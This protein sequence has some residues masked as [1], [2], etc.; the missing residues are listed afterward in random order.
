FEEDP[1]VAVSLRGEDDERGA[2]PRRKGREVADEL[3]ERLIEHRLEGGIGE[4][5][6]V[7]EAGNGLFDPR[8]N[9]LHARVDDP[10]LENVSD[11]GVD[12]RATETVSEDHQAAASGIVPIEVLLKFV[13]IRQKLDQLALADRLRGALARVEGQLF[14]WRYGRREPPPSDEDPDRSERPE[15]SFRFF[16]HH[17]HVRR[18]PG[19]QS[20]DAADVA[21]AKPRVARPAV[22]EEKQKYPRR[23]GPRRFVPEG[24]EQQ[25]ERRSR[26]EASL[27]VE[28]E[29]RELEIVVDFER[30]RFNPPPALFR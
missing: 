15:G 5:D 20:P 24:L 9:C 28:L 10:A 7:A 17:F 2:L 22:C 1:R 4:N 14:E 27:V 11:G 29:K 18:E 16:G 13:E 26:V 3:L 19:Q 8:Q 25:L 6:D 12:H 21:V 23:L 30:A